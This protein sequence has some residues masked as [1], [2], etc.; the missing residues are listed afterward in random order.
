ML[1]INIVKQRITLHQNSKW[2]YQEGLLRHTLLLNN[3]LKLLYKWLSLVYRLVFSHL[4]SK[5]SMQLKW[6]WINWY[7][8]YFCPLLQCYSSLSLTVLVHVIVANFF[9]KDMSSCWFKSALLLYQE[10]WCLRTRTCY[11]VTSGLPA[12]VHLTSEHLTCICMTVTM[13]WIWNIYVL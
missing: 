13:Q 7:T 6:Y 9:D 8:D 4:W 12:A 5:Y 11:R 2:W 3:R 1:Y 10:P